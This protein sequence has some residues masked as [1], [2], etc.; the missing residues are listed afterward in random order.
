MYDLHVLTDLNFILIL[1]VKW[2]YWWESRGQIIFLPSDMQLV[3]S[4]TNILHPCLPASNALALS[5]TFCSLFKGVHELDTFPECLFPCRGI[6][7]SV[8]SVP[9]LL[10][11][12]FHP[13][14]LEVASCFQ[15][16][17]HNAVWHSGMSSSVAA[18]LLPS[19]SP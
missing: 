14:K 7:L 12:P 1:W 17:S 5:T 11:G 2:Y 10:S 15:S 3:S 9:F 13:P 19:H 4:R 8:F 16:R 6:I 18:L